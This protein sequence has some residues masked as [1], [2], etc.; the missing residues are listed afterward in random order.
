[1]SRPIEPS[2]GQAPA[3]EAVATVIPRGSARTAAIPAGDTASLS[4]ADAVV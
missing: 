2:L 3:G 4:S 1:M